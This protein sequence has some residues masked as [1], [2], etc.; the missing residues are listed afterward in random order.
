MEIA[1]WIDL[2]YKF[3]IYTTQ[4]QVWAPVMRELSRYPLHHWY[5][6]KRPGSQQN[7]VLQ[8]ERRKFQVQE[9][10][11]IAKRSAVLCKEN[12][13]RKS[14][15]NQNL[16]D[17]RDPCERQEGRWGSGSTAPYILRFGTRLTWAVSFKPQSP[18]R[19]VN[20]RR[21]KLNGRL[22]DPTAGRDVHKKKIILAV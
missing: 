1:D 17:V 6:R 19:R 8:T 9:M 16:V 14:L 3:M 13:W 10:P 20:S 12:S 2:A 5:R 21:Y 11:N 7:K 18:Y 15:N 22:G 4:Q